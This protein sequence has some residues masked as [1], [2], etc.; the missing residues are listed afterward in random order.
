MA[1]SDFR[2]DLQGKSVILTAFLKC[3]ND[4]KD[5][6]APLTDEEADELDFELQAVMRTKQEILLDRMSRL[7]LLWVLNH[8]IGTAE[9]KAALK[10]NILKPLRAISR[11]T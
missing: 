8:Y 11:H 10:K 7:D 1:G 6:L 9:G 4:W 3:Y 5:A 2:Y